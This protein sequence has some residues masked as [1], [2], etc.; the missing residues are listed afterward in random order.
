MGDFELQIFADRLKEIRMQKKMT[1]KDFAEKIGVTAA[2]LSAY[3]NNVKN[4]SVSVAKKIGEKFGVSID[5]LC[6]LSDSQCR[7]RE[8]KTYKDIVD[9]LFEI[10]EYVGIVFWNDSDNAEELTFS[11][12]DFILNMF[13]KEWMQATNVRDNTTLSKEITKTMYDSWKKAKLEELMK[14]KIKK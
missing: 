12:E 14:K 11:F 5:W 9:V 10:D 13:M 4:P 3:E 1:Q 8:F 6:G 7:D 2:A